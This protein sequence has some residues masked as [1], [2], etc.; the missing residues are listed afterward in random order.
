MT[1]TVCEVMSN[2]VLRVQTV[3]QYCTD[4]SRHKLN[5]HQQGCYESYGVTQRYKSV[6]NSQNDSAPTFRSKTLKRV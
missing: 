1:A 2:T 3:D 4:H 6:P 5:E